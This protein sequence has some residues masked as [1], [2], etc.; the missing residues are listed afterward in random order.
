MAQTL[1]VKYRQPP[2]EELQGPFPRET[3]RSMWLERQ[4]RESLVDISRYVDSE[5]GIDVRGKSFRGLWHNG[6]FVLLMGPL[7]V[8]VFTTHYTDN[9]GYFN[10]ELV[11]VPPEGM[12]FKLE[13]YKDAYPGAWNMLVTAEISP[14]AKATIAAASGLMGFALIMLGLS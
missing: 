10:E 7:Y 4:A 14:L 8:R 3:L 6:D 2:L 9:E 1:Q 11:K 13:E 12:L 5:G